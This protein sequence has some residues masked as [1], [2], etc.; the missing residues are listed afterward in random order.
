MITNS[1]VVDVDKNHPSVAFFQDRRSYVTIAA[2][3]ATGRIIGLHGRDADGLTVVFN[4]FTE[5]KRKSV[6]V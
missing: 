2:E 1:V 3:K 4:A 5:W 6:D